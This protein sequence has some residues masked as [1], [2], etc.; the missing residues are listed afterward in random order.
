MIQFI[1]LSML[2][3]SRIQEKLRSRELVPVTNGWH[4]CMQVWIMIL[5]IHGKVYS[6]T[7]FLYQWA[8]SSIHHHYCSDYGYPC[9]HSSTFSHPQVLLTGRP[10]PHDQA[11][12]DST[13][14]HV[15]C[16]LPSPT[17]Q[18]KCVFF[19]EPQHLW[20]SHPTTT[21]THRPGSLLVH[22]RYFLEWM[23][24]PTPNGSITAY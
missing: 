16:L 13:A 24:Q 5:K 9:R 14:W 15:L 1:S 7:R 21:S 10:R 17:L 20:I 19:F 6:R 3:S 12:L 4:F 18:L 8:I 2:I 23:W 11:M 22:Q